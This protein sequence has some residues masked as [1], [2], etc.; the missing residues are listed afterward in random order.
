MYEI[1][2]KYNFIAYKNTL[3]NFFN[4]VRKKK[5]YIHPQRPLNIM[6]IIKLGLKL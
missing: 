1:D 2:F 6:K 4:M 5:I 3:T